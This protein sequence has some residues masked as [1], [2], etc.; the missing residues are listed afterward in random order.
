M[1]HAEQ[2]D[3][4]RGELA[5]SRDSIPHDINVKLPSNTWIDPGINMKVVPLGLKR[6]RQQYEL[7]LQPTFN[8]ECSGTFEKTMGVPCNHTIRELMGFNLKVLAAHFD[9]YW[10]YN[11]PVPAPPV[12][13]PDPL[14]DVPAQLGM[15]GLASI[16]PLLPNSADISPLPP[17]VGLARGGHSWRSLSGGSFLRVTCF[18]IPRRRYYYSLLL[19]YHP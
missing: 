1:F 15:I 10:L 6:L 3:K 16:D 5:R 19:M 13:A 12:L 9:A 14:H 2:Y 18:A 17:A 8:Y 4:I 7:T 11:R